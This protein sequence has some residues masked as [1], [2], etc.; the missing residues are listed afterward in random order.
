MKPPRPAAA[1]D[2]TARRFYL[3]GPA[4]SGWDKKAAQEKGVEPAP[5]FL[6]GSLAALE[7]IGVPKAHVARESYGWN[8]L[9]IDPLAGYLSTNSVES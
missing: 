5:R 9:D 7:E 6:E 1:S 3:C 8:P 4:V 2:P